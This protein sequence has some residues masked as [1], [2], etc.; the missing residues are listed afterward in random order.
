VYIECTVMFSDDELDDAEAWIFECINSARN[1]DFLVDVWGSHRSAASG[2]GN[3]K[4]PHRS[5]SGWHLLMRT[6]SWPKSTPEA[7]RLTASSVSVTGRLRWVPGQL[8]PTIEAKP[9]A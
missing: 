1:P 8:N 4:L 3:P 9:N 5:R 7:N 6:L 2:Q